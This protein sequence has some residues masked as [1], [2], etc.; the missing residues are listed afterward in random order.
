VPAG[1]P[2]SDPGD[3]PPSTEEAAA[4]AAYLARKRRHADMERG[5][6]AEP[7]VANPGS[8]VGTA[9][10]VPV[11]PAAFPSSGG[12]WDEK[13]HD[14]YPGMAGAGFGDGWPAA[15]VDGAGG[16]RRDPGDRMD[17]GVGRGA[18]VWDDRAWPA[19]S[20]G[21]SRSRAA[22]GREDPWGAPTAARVLGAML[23]PAGTGTRR[24]STTA[25]DTPP[26]APGRP[27]GRNATPLPA[28]IRTRSRGVTAG[29]IP[30]PVPGRPP[31]RT[32]TPTTAGTGTR[33]PNSTAGDTPPAAPGRPP[34][35]S[36][37]P[38]PATIGTRSRGGT[39]KDTPPPVPGRPPG[40]TATPT[41]AALGARSPAGTAGSTPPMPPVPA[42]GVR[43]PRAGTPVPTT[44]A[45]RRR[46]WSLG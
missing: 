16:A 38:L 34:G 9:P 15:A 20:Q 5:G 3:V 32:A 36:A 33:S 31:G 19:A 12:R 30:P 23:T 41:T 43:A 2:L 26:A 25:G 13:R 24:P 22:A 7:G 37:T 21:D 4:S 10:D 28:E 6:S 35:R 27:P 11:G 18:G 29:D 46:C 17:G 40:R 45:R 39:A 1:F 42:P 14:N 8:P 44:T